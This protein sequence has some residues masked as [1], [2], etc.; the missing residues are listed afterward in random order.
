[1]NRDVVANN[2]AMGYELFHRSIYALY[3]KKATDGKT[4]AFTVTTFAREALAMSNRFYDS[5]LRHI[6]DYVAVSTNGVSEDAVNRVNGLREILINKLDALTTDS[7]R[8]YQSK[9]RNGALFGQKAGFTDREFDYRVKDARGRSL[10]PIN[11]VTGLVRSFATDTYFVSAVDLL[12]T[13]GF[14]AKIVYPDPNHKNN[15]LVFD[16]TDN[17]QV[18][19]FAQLFHPYSQATVVANVIHS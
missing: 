15:G 5:G 11:Y 16:P 19:V 6:N 14:N 8:Y 1:M 13:N 7:I 12:A 18:K 4:D 17:E 2:I 9:L 3:L 10:D